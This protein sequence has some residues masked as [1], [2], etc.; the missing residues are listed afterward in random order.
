MHVKGTLDCPSTGGKRQAV[1]TKKNV[2]SYYCQM[3]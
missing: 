2:V 1:N 3:K